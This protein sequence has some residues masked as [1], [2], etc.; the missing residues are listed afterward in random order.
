MKVSSCVSPT[1]QHKLKRVRH[2]I[3]QIWRS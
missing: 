2:F 1:C 3:S